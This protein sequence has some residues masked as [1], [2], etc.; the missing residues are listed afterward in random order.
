MIRQNEFIINMLYTLSF[1]QIDCNFILYDEKQYPYLCG[2]AIL[3]K[4]RDYILTESN[5]SNLGMNLKHKN[6]IETLS[7]DYINKYYKCVLTDF[8]MR[9]IK[10]ELLNKIIQ[11]SFYKVRPNS[12][13]EL[14]MSYDSTIIRTQLETFY[15]DEGKRLRLEI[16]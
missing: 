11:I 13:C 2:K 16:L 5:F 10:P 1:K 9:Y 12:N 8:N 14:T 3:D 15:N 4:N 6:I 7:K